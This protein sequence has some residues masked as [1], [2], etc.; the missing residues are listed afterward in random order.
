MDDMNTRKTDLSRH[1]LRFVIVAIGGQNLV[2]NCGTARSTEQTV[3]VMV[4]S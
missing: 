4:H 1:V 2:K 3:Y